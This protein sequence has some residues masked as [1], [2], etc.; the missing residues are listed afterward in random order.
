MGLLFL[1]Y[2]IFAEFWTD[3]L[4]CL[5][6]SDFFSHFRLSCKELALVPSQLKMHH[7]RHFSES[8]VNA[9]SVEHAPD[10]TKNKGAWWQTHHSSF[11]SRNKDRTVSLAVI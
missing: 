11:M 5:G 9:F 6:S 4:L 7:V 3:C 2:L 8:K 1:K 10:L